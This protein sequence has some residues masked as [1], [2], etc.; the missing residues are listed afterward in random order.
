M[1]NVYGS[2]AAWSISRSPDK[3][4]HDQ[5]ILYEIDML[6]FTYDRM[7]SMWPDAREADLWVFLESFLLH[8]RNLIEFFG[9]VP[10]KASDLSIRRL[11]EIWPDPHSRPSEAEITAMQTRGEA[12]RLKYEDSEKNDTISKYLQH[13]TKHRIQAKSWQPGEMMY[14]IAELISLFEKHVRSFRP[15]SDSIR[16]D[17][18]FAKPEPAALYVPSSASE[19]RNA[20]A[21]PA[22][23]EEQKKDGIK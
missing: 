8:Y 9:K 15:A 1:L 11:D 2:P 16:M 13:C 17:E 20:S 6:R 19:T 3:L 5:T 18:I 23:I 21:I 4:S 10:A 7:P 14:D 22:S 12:L